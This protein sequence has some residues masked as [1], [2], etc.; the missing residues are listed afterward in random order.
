MNTE[1][2]LARGERRG[3]GFA[4]LETASHTALDP[5]GTGPSDVWRVV[6]VADVS[7]P[8]VP[9]AR[10]ARSGA[11]AGGRDTYRGGEDAEVGLGE[12]GGARLEGGGGASAELH[13]RRSGNQSYRPTRRR[14]GRKSVR[15]VGAGEAECREVR[16]VDAV[17]DRAVDARGSR[18]DAASRRSGRARSPRR[19]TRVPGEA[20]GGDPDRTEPGAFPARDASR[21]I[22]PGKRRA[23]A[24]SK[25]TL[26]A[27]Q[28]LAAAEMFMMAAIL[29]ECFVTT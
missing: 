11:G 28:T 2:D 1:F 27:L 10:A 20:S 24:R 4:L 5:L 17:R 3:K 18:G 16:R 7:S 25:R 9:R 15:R 29:T 13:L 23:G 14:V 8:A 6:R 19:R 21:S 12:D 26:G 22:R